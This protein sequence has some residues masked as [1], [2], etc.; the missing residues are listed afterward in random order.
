VQSRLEESDLD[1]WR[2]SITAV[3][4]TV[5][6]AYFN[7]WRTIMDIQKFEF[8]S[9]KVNYIRRFAAKVL[10]MSGNLDAKLLVFKVGHTAQLFESRPYE[11]WTSIA[12]GKDW[13]ET[14][15]EF[16]EFV[17]KMIVESENFFGVSEFPNII[18]MI[19][20]LNGFIAEL[21]E[22]ERI[23]EEDT[24]DAFDDGEP[25]IDEDALY[26]EEQQ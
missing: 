23:P 3:S 26:A 10:G 11:D 2:T 16:I 18:E 5:R 9:W 12:D 1:G 13:E 7:P 19:D 17:F 22:S 21:V 20:Q 4:L 25:I 15:K 24:G 14:S 6:S 8:D